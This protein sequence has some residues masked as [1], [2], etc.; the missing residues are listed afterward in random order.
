MKNAT[1]GEV[2]S[3]LRMSSDLT[4][5]FL[6][7]N[8]VPKEWADY[9][10][11]VLKEATK[12]FDWI[13]LSKEP[14]DYGLNDHTVSSEGLE[15]IYRKVLRGA[16]LAKTEYIAVV[17]DDTLYHSSHFDYRPREIAYDLNR[18][19]TFTWGK[20]FYFLKSRKTN[21]GM[22]AKR[23]VVIKTIEDRYKNFKVGELPR[24]L[25]YEVGSLPGEPQPELYYGLYPFL[26]LSHRFAIDELEQKEHKKPWPIRAYDIPVWGRVEEI[27]KR[28][29][30]NEKN[31]R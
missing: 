26:S 21:A 25:I 4:I 14:V 9:H 13:T 8:K 22:I 31:N 28:F 29:P 6:T 23:E 17:E 12:G 2:G 27:R 3:F 7:A 16:K 30:E 11:S 10:L 24:E 19:A 5:L 20:S 15:N 18:W 1:N